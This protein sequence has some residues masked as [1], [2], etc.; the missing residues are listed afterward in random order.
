LGDPSRC[1]SAGDEGRV[2]FCLTPKSG[3]IGHI[4]KIGNNSNLKIAA[5]PLKQSNGI[6]RAKF[7]VSQIKSGILLVIYA[8]CRTYPFAMASS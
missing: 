2:N 6:K 7:E 1:Q 3:H 8:A 4:G 5:K